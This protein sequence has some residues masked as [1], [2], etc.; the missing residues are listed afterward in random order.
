MP[1]LVTTA[2]SATA[3]SFATLA[4]FTTYCDGRLN[5]ST[6]VDA[7]DDD[8]V[9][10]ALIEATKELTLLSYIGQQTSTTQALAWP[11]SLAQNPASLPYLSWYATTEI[12]Q[13]IIDATCEYALQFLKAGTSDLAG[14]D[15]AK[16][17]IEKT[18]GP[19]TTRFSEPYQR[20]SG[21]RKYPRVWALV[22]PLLCSVS[23]N[24]V[25][26]IRG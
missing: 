20:A 17:V 7:A 2:G 13:R 1:T 16:N 3:N 21:M 5:A 26:V 15:T 11:R 4:Q 6:T 12:P 19:L 18:V 10:R 23:P 9:L 14:Q 25:E 22:E 8:D 24:V